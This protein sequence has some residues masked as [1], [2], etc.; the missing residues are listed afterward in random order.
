MMVLN[1]IK[2]NGDPYNKIPNKFYD[3]IDG[4]LKL[5]DEDKE[6]YRIGGGCNND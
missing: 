3:D 6:K 4:W 1:P 5:N 2:K